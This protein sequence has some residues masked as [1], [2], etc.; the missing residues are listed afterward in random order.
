[1][2]GIRPEPMARNRAGVGG[3]SPARRWEGNVLTALA[4]AI[5][6]DE[7]VVPAGSEMELGMA[8]ELSV[9]Q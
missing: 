4:Y 8:E 1:M 3:Q 9:S 6:S 7:N 5:A 2:L